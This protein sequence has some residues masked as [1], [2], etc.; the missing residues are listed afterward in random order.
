MQ[1]RECLQR[2]Q[3]FGHVPWMTATA[4]RLGLQ[5]RLRPRG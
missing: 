3:L 4:R 5:A 1:L 2:T